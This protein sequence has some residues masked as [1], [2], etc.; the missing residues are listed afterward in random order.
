MV[1]DELLWKVSKSNIDS[2]NPSWSSWTQH[3]GAVPIKGKG[4]TYDRTVNVWAPLELVMCIYICFALGRMVLYKQSMG[5]D[6]CLVRASQTTD[7][8]LQRQRET[9]P[10]L[11]Y[12]KRARLDN[13]DPYG[14]RTWFTRL[15]IFCHLLENMNHLHM[16]RFCRNMIQAPAILYI[17]QLLLN[18]FFAQSEVCVRSLISCSSFLSRLLKPRHHCR[19]YDLF[20]KTPDH[21]RWC[22]NRNWNS[23]AL[24]V[25]KISCGKMLSCVSVML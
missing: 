23:L 25:P 19:L 9:S 24:L 20:A 16:F 13:G 6:P 21:V 17:V 7:N 8:S 5:P 1:W 12:A 10:T 3:E 14:W 15:K 18:C 11:K 2:Q 4:K 22:R